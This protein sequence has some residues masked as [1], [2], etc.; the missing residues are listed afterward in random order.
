MKLLIIRHAEPD[1]KHDSLT[2]KG[3]SEA[4]YLAQLLCK[5]EITYIYASPYGRAQDT[6]SLT[7]K[8]LNRTAVTLPW[9]REFEA[10]IHRPDALI[11]KVPWDWLP[12]D[13]TQDPRFYD[14]DHW[15]ENERMAAGGVGEE[16]CRVTEGFDAL[17]AQHGYRRADGYYRAERS[18]HDTIALFCHFGVGCVLLS[19]LWGVS[20][21]VI[22]HG[23][24]AQASSVTTLVTEE[25]R[26]GIASFRMLAFGETTHLY[27]HD[28]SPSFAARFCECYGDDTR[29]D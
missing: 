12:Q 15:A 5:Q 9:L 20:P 24:C 1:Y 3:W 13:W 18:N 25:R 2:D 28:E 17:L 16:Y 7:L 11:K 6:A 8:Q 21:M 14:K 29:H 22:W 26:K 27:V 19:R 4:E 23:T 10:P